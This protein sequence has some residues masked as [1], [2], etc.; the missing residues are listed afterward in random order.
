MAYVGVHFTTFYN[1]VIV[2]MAEKAIDTAKHQNIT[3]K[4]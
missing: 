3:N 1:V 4:M 2:K